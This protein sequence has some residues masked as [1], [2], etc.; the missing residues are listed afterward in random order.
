MHDRVID[1]GWL[2]A[3]GSAAMQIAWAEVL[4]ADH[5]VTCDSSTLSWAEVRGLNVVDLRRQP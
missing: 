4:E 2:G 1:R 5:F 3:P